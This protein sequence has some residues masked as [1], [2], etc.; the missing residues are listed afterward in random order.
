VT[1]SLADRGVRVLTGVAAHEV[2]RAELTHIAKYQARVVSELIDGSDA[3]ATQDGPL[4]PRD[5]R[6]ELLGA[7]RNRHC[8]VHHRPPTR[9]ARRRTFIGPEVADLLHA[10]TIAIA[11]EVAIPPPQQTLVLAVSMSARSTMIQPARTTEF[12]ASIPTPSPAASIAT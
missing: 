7:R 8:P 3:I 4:S 2:E 11:G 10:A 6:G 5:R 9:G 12:G 1:C